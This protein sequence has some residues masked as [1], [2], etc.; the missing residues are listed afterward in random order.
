MV[1]TSIQLLDLIEKD[2]L[3]KI[4]RDFTR[5]TRVA[6][7]L[8]D[9]DGQPITREHNFCRLC[10]D[11]CR[12][13]PEGRA[14]CYASDRFGGEEGNKATG[15]PF[16][17]KC[18]NAGLMDSA[19][20]IVVEGY[21]VAT[22]VMGQV[23]T[24]PLSLEAAIESAR[25]IGIED[26]AGYLNALRE[27]P[28][29]GY[30]RL[31]SVVRLMDTIAKTISS[32]AIQKYLSQK[33]SQKNLYNIM[34]SVSEVIVSTDTEGIITL[35][36]KA[37]VGMFNRD[38][39][40]MVGQPI[41]TLFQDPGAF[42]RY[43]LG[44]KTRVALET[45]QT[46]EALGKEGQLFY[47]QASCQKR[48]KFRREADGYVVVLRDVTE[49][50]RVEK[51]KEDL[52]GMLTHDMSNP[53]L[54]TQRVLELL[55]DGHIGSLSVKG[56][57]LVSLALDS[58][59]KLSGMVSN[60]LDIF[61][62]ESNAL[63]LN[64]VEGNLD[65]ALQESIRQVGFSAGDKNVAV[66]FHPGNASLRILADWSRIQ[67]TCV[68]LLENAIRFSPEGGI[69]HIRAGIKNGNG[70]NRYLVVAIEDQGIGIEPD[71]QS[72]VFEKFYTSDRR[73]RAERRGVGLGLTFSKM[74]VEAH[75]GN[76]WVES[77]YVD[78]CGREVSGCS[79][80]FRIPAPP[81]SEIPVTTEQR[82]G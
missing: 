42:R 50:K 26:V 69:I 61:L 55:L 62:D 19:T 67:R 15:K 2:V 48:F 60:F 5:A 10:R 59:H 71:K 76:I 37:A 65:G 23:L 7:V 12:S 9:T 16:I 44:R 24:K 36:N 43:L 22:L 58:T 49:E 14:R 8:V 66:H 21:H 64:F 57:D 72:L 80:R 41:F 74:A 46:F 53:I 29:M 18:L 31:K 34:N 70:L 79:F 78:R 39:P 3:E 75:G 82:Y 35:V 52:I 56:N 45:S 77:P 51:M 25:A 1:Q 81:N 54:S 4:V 47:V 17:Y 73:S 68:N 6:S 20:P 40:S 32:L 63:T 38:I 33:A 11:F 30:Q 13:T 28:V 27:V